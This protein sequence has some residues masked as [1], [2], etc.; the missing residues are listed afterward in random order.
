MKALAE[1]LR[2]THCLS[3]EVAVRWC[4]WQVDKAKGD[5]AVLVVCAVAIVLFACGVI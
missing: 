5:L 3:A 2:V 1:L 4:Q